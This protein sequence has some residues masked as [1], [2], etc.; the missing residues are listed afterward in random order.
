M[1]TGIDDVDWASMNHAYGDASDVPELLR[2]LASDDPD[3]REGALD[4]M[5]GAVHH[6]GDVYDCTV[7]SLPF[8]FALLLEPTVPDRG[9]ILELLCSV[10]GETEPDPDEIWTDFE[11]EEEHAAWVANYVTASATVRGRSAEL[12][13]LLDD[14][15]PELRA[16]VPGAL[17]QLHADGARVLEA[18]RGR[19]DAEPDADAVRALVTALAELAVRHGGDGA[20]TAGDAD[21]AE[22]AA[23]CLVRVAHQARPRPELLLAALTGLARCAP[24]LLPPRAVEWV[25]EAMREA[26]EAPSPVPEPGE[27]RPRTGTPTTM[28]AYLR[29]LHA[30]HRAALDADEAIELLQRLHT[31]L[32]DRTD[33]RLELLVDQLRSPSRGQRRAA[34]GQAGLLLSGWRL[35]SDEAIEL[36]A[37]QLTGGDARVAC[38]ALR[39]L[40]FLHPLA[41]G[42]ADVI[43]ASLATYRHAVEGDGDGRHE[44]AV[45]A[46]AAQ[47]DPRAVPGLTRLLEDEPPSL[48]LNVS[49]RAVAA[50]SAP[51]GPV[52]LTRLSRLRSGAHR[53]RA[54]FLDALAVP[55]PPEGLPLAARYA[56]SA[57]AGTRHAAFRLLARYGREAAPHADTVRAR[58][59][60]EESPHRG[61]QAAEALW[62]ITGEADLD[63]DRDLVLTAV[64][65]MLRAERPNDRAQGIETA[66]RLGRH[67]APLTPLLRERLADDNH[68]TTAALALWRIEGDAEE[69]AG[70]LVEQW[71]RTPYRLP[72]IAA[73]LAGLG[74]AAAAAIPLA[75]AELARTRRH[76]NNDAATPNIRYHVD[77][78]EALRADCR[79]ILAAAAQAT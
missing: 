53:R 17:V 26:R 72:A 28:V 45:E 51:L 49:V 71:S 33:A 36:I 21:T 2:G 65:R 39:E 12:F 48:D 9:T 11:D 62:Q 20:E 50:H 40:T 3:E 47:G 54:L 8:L 27:D 6:Q 56:S 70:L 1:L 66:G 25:R 63:L 58:V 55:A 69:T 22:G 76:G 61:M 38:E 14:P 5:Y 24:A 4:G 29:E 52:I 37:R 74:P 46:L 73:C 42:V 59:T 16:V 67:A 31:A 41:H 79:R 75:R 60:A 64:T 32:A 10:A 34:L 18:L 23:D 78:D 13:P 19:L 68:R 77:Q 7:A 30:E 43:A 44:R 57:D 35:P 15:D